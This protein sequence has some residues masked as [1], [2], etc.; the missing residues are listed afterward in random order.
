MRWPLRFAHRSW[1]QPPLRLSRRLGHRAMTAIA[2]SFRCRIPKFSIPTNRLCRPAPCIHVSST[3]ALP[4]FPGISTSFRCRIRSCFI[5]SLSVLRFRFHH[6][7]DLADGRERTGTGHA[8][9]RDTVVDTPREVPG[10]LLACWH[11]PPLGDDAT[12]QVTVRMRIRA[13]RIDHRQAVRDLC[14]DWAGHAMRAR[15][16]W[17][18]SRRR[19]GNARPSTSPQGSAPP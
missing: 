16:W 12:H 15:P 5:R 18:R 14:E 4:V 9:D 17:I 11:P 8:A 3:R 19:S 13:R 1:P 7:R 6:D 2:I 10:R